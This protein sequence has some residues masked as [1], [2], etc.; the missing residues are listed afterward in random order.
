MACPRLLR[1]PPVQADAEQGAVV[2]HV[3]GP[4]GPLPAMKEAA[5]TFSKEKHVQVVVTGGPLPKWLH[6][7][8]QNADLIYSGSEEM[9]S[10]FQIALQG[11]LDPAPSSRFTSE[12]P[13]S[14]CVPAIHPTFADWRI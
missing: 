4:G 14:W 10:D 8:Q 11:T 6:D 7:A 3:Y 12:R 13:R 2:L 5:E 9:M 1:A